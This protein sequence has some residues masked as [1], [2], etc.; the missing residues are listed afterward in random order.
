MN[1]VEATDAALG[2]ILA[3]VEREGG[4]ALVTAFLLILPQVLSVD[5]TYKAS[6]IGVYAVLGLSVVV[7]TGWGGGIIIAATH[8]PLGIETRELRMGARA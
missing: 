7:L 6:V 3:A 4:V 8:A 5:R 1:A 2:R